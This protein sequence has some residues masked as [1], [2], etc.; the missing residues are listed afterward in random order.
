MIEQLGQALGEL[1]STLESLLGNNSAANSNEEV[2]AESGAS[3]S[4][5]GD[6]LQ[7]VFEILK[8]LLGS[9]E[10]FQQGQ[11]TASGTG[12]LTSGLSEF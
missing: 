6:P 9:I 4:E 3:A 2:S 5:Q 12:A 7:Q 11:G 8:Q 1:V 10:Q